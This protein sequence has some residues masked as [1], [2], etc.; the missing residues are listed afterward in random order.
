MKRLAGLSTLALIISST[1]GCGWLWGDEGYFRDRS[2]DYLDAR[3]TAPMRMPANV[4]AKRLD[5]LLP[6]PAHVATSTATPQEFEVPRPQPVGVAGQASEFSLQKSGDSRWL[7]AQRT[8]AEVWP[9]ARSYFENNG[10][11]IAD[12]RPQTG[13]FSTEWQ[14]PA[15]LAPSMGRRVGS[16]LADEDN[17]VRVRVRIEPGVVRGTSEVFVSSV[18]REEGSSADVAFPAR[19][20]IAS[21]EASLLDG[22]RDD[23]SSSAEHGSVSLLAARSFDA[24]SRVSLTQDGAGNPVLN[25]STDFD[26][27]WSS[28]GRALELADVR[29][30]DINRSLGVYYV[31]LA[32]GAKKPEEEKGF[33][34]GLFGSEPTKEEINARA[35]R[36]Q[37]RLTS[38]AN[39]DVQVSVEKDINT[40]APEDVSRRVLTLIQENLG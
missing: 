38:N 3:Q 12:E 7:V 23:L 31:N 4:D 24:P 29:I 32:E 14:A 17:Q 25:L 26:R 6:V 19:T 35:E 8:P 15:E 5:P 11:R 33:L 20:G 1:S 18:E 21:L 37:V 27:A 34:S 9:V 22:M 36:Y 39:G 2:T 28:V 40:V 30:D 13:E 10:F 16:L